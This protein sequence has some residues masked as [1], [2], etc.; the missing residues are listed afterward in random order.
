[1]GKLISGLFLLLGLAAALFGASAL[2]MQ[3][4]TAAPAEVSSERQA[5]P[6]QEDR[7][8]APSPRA[9]ASEPIFN[10]ASTGIVSPDTKTSFQERLYQVPVAYEAPK[11]VAF[12]RSFNV[13]FA[14]DG[15]GGESAADA[16]PGKD[17]NTVE[18]MA[19]ISDRLKALLVG[20]EFE[21]ELLSPETQRLSLLTENVWRWRVTPQTAG[22][23]A[24]ILELYALDGD[25]A[26]PVRTFSDEV[27]VSVSTIQRVLGAADSANPLMVLLGGIGSAIGG[28][29]GFFRFFRKRR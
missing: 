10:T 14:I 3:N 16:L 8:S 25:E 19:K 28:F 1:M 17:D 13:T 18:D 4:D 7:D 5:L 20:S 11:T 29:F 27:V 12:G 23:H 26:V 24:L 9:N 2:Y 22:E 21:I 15:T 6:I